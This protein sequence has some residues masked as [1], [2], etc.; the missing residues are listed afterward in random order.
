MV[1]HGVDLGSD[2][3]RRFCERW[4]IQELAVFG[5][6][7]DDRFRPDNDVDLLAS[8]EEDAPWDLLDLL[9]MQDEASQILGRQVE[10]VSRR[11]IE[12]NANRIIKREVLGTAETVYAK[13]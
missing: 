2:V 11:G 10:I 6:I 13:Q 4:R 1:L 12:Q 3:I 5:S 9:R 8:F 7:L